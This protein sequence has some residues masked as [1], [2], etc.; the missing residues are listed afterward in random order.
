MERKMKQQAKRQEQEAQAERE[1]LARA[2]AVQR[3]AAAASAAVDRDIS[4]GNIE[5]IVSALRNPRNAHFQHAWQTVQTLSEQKDPE[6]MAPSLELISVSTVPV[7]LTSKSA[8]QSA[9]L[10]SRVLLQLYSVIIK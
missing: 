9:S 2:E 1:Q 10:F 5:A 8:S 3:K 4:S 7:R 6:G